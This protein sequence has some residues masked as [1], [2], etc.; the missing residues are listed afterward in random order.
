MP[1]HTL[2]IQ[3]RLASCDHAISVTVSHEGRIAHAVITREALEERWDV[4]PAPEDLLRTLDAHD[5]EVAE[6]VLRR[7]GAS[8]RRPLLVSMP[9]RLD[10]RKS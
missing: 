5:T 8:G 4:G 3:A 6:A 10:D 2:S 9:S 1:A 7:C